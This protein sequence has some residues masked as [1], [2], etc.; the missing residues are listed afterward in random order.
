MTDRA[1]G[2]IHDIGYQRYQGPRLGRGYAVGSLLTHSLRTAYG[3]GRSAKAKVF[4]WLVV[5]IVGVVAVVVTAIRSVTGE[6][7]LSYLDF[8]DAV[9]PLA[10]LFCA[11]VAP[12]L[13]SRDLRSGVL[14]LYFS[15]PLRR[16]DYGLAKLAALIG[17]VWLLLTGPMLVMFLGGVFSVDGWR[18]VWDEVGDFGSGLAYAALHA[19]LVSAVSLLIASL[20]SRRAVA[21]PI[22]VAAFLVTLPIVGLL[23]TAGGETA[24]QLSG[25]FSPETLLVGVRVWLAPEPDSMD[26]GGFGPLYGAVTVAL[27]AACAGLLL[28][29]YRRVRA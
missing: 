23:E 29:R 28:V 26:L 21:A 14:S 8:P 24:R 13:V 19:V 3:L 9:F 10:V 15:R 22:V 11:V 4:P 20:V 25:L 7:V 12:E 5:G 18:A 1:A 6:V 2:V 17:A 16:T 27:V